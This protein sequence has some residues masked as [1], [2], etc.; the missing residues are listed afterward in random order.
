MTPLVM[1]RRGNSVRLRNM[2]LTCC[3]LGVT[4]CF[5]V[6]IL[7]FCSV[8]WLCVIGM[9]LV[10]VCSSAAPLSLSGLSRVLNLLWVRLKEMLLIMCALLSL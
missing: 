3:D 2:T 8:T 7:S 6:E 5:G 4:V 1:L 9:R 10:T